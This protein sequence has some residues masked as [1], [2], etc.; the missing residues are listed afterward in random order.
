MDEI[1]WQFGKL[2]YKKWCRENPKQS[3]VSVG[4]VVMS[5]LLAM[6]ATGHAAKQLDADGS[7]T[8][9]ATDKFMVGKKTPRGSLVSF[10]PHLQ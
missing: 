10:G 8:W 3:D 1:L 2:Y 9:T 5:L 6:E 4:V 7:V